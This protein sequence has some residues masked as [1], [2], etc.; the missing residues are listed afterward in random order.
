MEIPS[1]PRLEKVFSSD[2][3]YTETE[4]FQGLAG[5]DT[6]NLANFDF[7]SLPNPEEPLYIEN[8]N[9]PSTKSELE[10]LNSKNKSVLKELRRNVFIYQAETNHIS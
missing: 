7:F 2:E 9:L 6:T 4:G 3:S 10:S 8:I 5:I 1:D